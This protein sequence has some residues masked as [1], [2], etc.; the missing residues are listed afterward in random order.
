MRLAYSLLFTVLAAANASA[1]NALPP[2]AAAEAWKRLDAQKAVTTAGYGFV[3]YGSDGEILKAY[4]PETPVTETSEGKLTIL[5]GELPAGAVLRTED[6]LTYQSAFQTLA[7]Q[8][9]KTDY[10]QRL[11]EIVDEINKGAVYIKD[12]LCPHPARPSN[13]TLEVAGG[14][15]FGVHGSLTSTVDWDL[16]KLCSVKDLAKQAKESATQQ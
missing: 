10:Q 4:G 11:E 1:Q 2:R 3:V 13:M 15:S 16:E 9:E 12:T 8:K 7:L 14:F 5:G 6:A